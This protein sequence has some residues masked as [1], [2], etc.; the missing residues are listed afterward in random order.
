M[1]S[2]S[3]NFEKKQ[4][5]NTPLSSRELYRLSRRL[6][7]WDSLA[8]LLDIS[9]ADRNNVRSCDKYDDDRSRAQEILSI[10]NRREDFSREKLACCLKEIQQI[11]LMEPVLRGDWRSLII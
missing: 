10:F 4:L 6:V 7:D 8:G 1:S 5:V 11:D 3:Q 9:V 2:Q